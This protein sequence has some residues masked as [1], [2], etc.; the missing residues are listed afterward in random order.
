MTGVRLRPNGLSN[1]CQFKYRRNGFQTPLASTAVTN[2]MYK[3][4]FD[5]QAS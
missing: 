1:I 4:Q 2:V 3:L 5:L